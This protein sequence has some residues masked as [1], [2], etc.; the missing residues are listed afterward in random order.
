MRV[1]VVLL[2]VVAWMLLCTSARAQ[3]PMTYD[4]TFYTDNDFY[5][6]RNPFSPYARQ[7]HKIRAKQ[8]PG[9]LV[10]M[11]NFASGV[12]SNLTTGAYKMVTFL[13][14]VNNPNNSIPQIASGPGSPLQQPGSLTGSAADA[15]KA[16]PVPA[17]LFAPM[18]NN[19]NLFPKPPGT[20]V[21]PPAGLGRAQ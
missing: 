1:T 11:Q 5:N 3:D 8:H 6:P 13:S 19:F 4:P 17:P 10:K 20:Q 12:A 7:L 16:T 18:T 9:M 14:A 21:I 15:M 2:V